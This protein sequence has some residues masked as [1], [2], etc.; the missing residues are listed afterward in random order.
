MDFS[1]NLTLTGRVSS[2]L[3][4]V[5]FCAGS[6]TIEVKAPC[7]SSSVGVCS[8]LVHGTACHS[9]S[10]FHLPQVLFKMCIL[11]LSGLVFCKRVFIP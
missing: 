1:E 11:L 10:L 3:L 5:L 8:G 7:F 6:L 2:N 9:Q 4:S